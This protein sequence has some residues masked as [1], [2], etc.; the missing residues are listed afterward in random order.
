MQG[1][2][3]GRSLRI[4]QGQ[5]ALSALSGA[6][7]AMA[8]REAMWGQLGG[9]LRKHCAE[10]HTSWMQYLHQRHSVGLCAGDGPERE[11]HARAQVR[12]SAC[13]PAHSGEHATSRATSRTQG[14]HNRRHKPRWWTSFAC[15]ACTAGCALQSGGGEKSDGALGGQ[16]GGRAM[17]ASTVDPTGLTE[18][19]TCKGP[20]GGRD[21][22]QFEND[23]ILFARWGVPGV[24]KN[25]DGSVSGTDGTVIGYV[26][27]AD[28]DGRDTNDASAGNAK[29]SGP[30]FLEM[31][32]AYLGSRDGWLRTMQETTPPPQTERQPRYLGGIR[33]SGSIVSFMADSIEAY[34]ESPATNNTAHGCKGPVLMLNLTLMQACT[35]Y[36]GVSLPIAKEH[37]FD[38][39]GN[40]P[41]L[42]TDRSYLHDW[43]KFHALSIAPA[44]SER[45]TASSDSSQRTHALHQ[46]MAV[47]VLRP[48][49]PLKDADFVDT[50]FSLTLTGCEANAAMQGALI[51]TLST[52]EDACQM[53][54]DGSE[55]RDDREVLSI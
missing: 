19:V 43:L 47:K 18:W 22:W 41:Y 24:R 2:F 12:R 5:I 35:S 27:V 44:Q 45:S 54:P 53:P 17:G 48:G 46:S 50:L 16:L 21:T 36:G 4:T 28:G 34:S 33:K 26:C 42:A 9:Q 11:A 32:E 52:D 13:A 3:A 14:L 25:E 29:P 1:V 51:E 30:S 15:V 38:A 40:P 39:Q 7:P 6:P 20:M 49:T 10:I 37:E 31:H 8:C 55:T 23:E